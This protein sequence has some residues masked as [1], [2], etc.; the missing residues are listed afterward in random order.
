[1]LLAI[2]VNQ[3]LDIIHADI[4]RAF[5]KALLDTDIWLQ[6]SPGISFQSQNGKVLKVAKLMEAAGLF[7]WNRTNVSFITSTKTLGILCLL[8]VKLM[9]W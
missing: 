5:L 6:L 9:T 7:S 8:V 1:M 3:G 2:A 4:P